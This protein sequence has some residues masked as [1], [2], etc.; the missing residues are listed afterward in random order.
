MSCFTGNED[1]ALVFT[2][3]TGTPLRHSNFR[4]RNWLAAV[5]AVGLTGIHFHDL[6][7]AGNTLTAEAGANLRE[8]MERMGHSSTKAA[9][10]YLHSTSERQRTLADAVGKLARSALRKAKKPEGDT[11]ASGTKVARRRKS[12]S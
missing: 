8:L 9:L 6:R 3:P 12:A 7:H 11:Q 10:V 1:D 2:S 4:R 5:E